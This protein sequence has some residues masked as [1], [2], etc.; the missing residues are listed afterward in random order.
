ME[1]RDHR[2]SG[3]GPEAD[4]RG[5]EAQPLHRCRACPYLLREVRLQRSLHQG[6]VDSNLLERRSLA[7]H[8]ADPAPTTRPFPVVLSKGSITVQPGEEIGD[9]VVKTL[10]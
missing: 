6:A 2:T 3:M 4:S 10:Q 1:S 9:L 7:E 5:K 8:P